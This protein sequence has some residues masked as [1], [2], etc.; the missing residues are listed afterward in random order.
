MKLISLIFKKTALLSAAGFFCLIQWIDVS[1]VLAGPLA[2]E[3][4][5]IAKE[6]VEFDKLMLDYKDLL[7]MGEIKQA[8][9]LNPKLARSAN[10]LT[11]VK[12][13]SS[14]IEKL[15]SGSQGH[16]T[17]LKESKEKAAQA[18]EQ[19]KNLQA[20]LEDLEKRLSDKEAELSKS[21]EE[22][23]NSQSTLRS[24][25]LKNQSAQSNLSS[26]QSKLQSAEAKVDDCKY[27]LTQA[28]SRLETCEAKSSAAG[29][30]SGLTTSSGVSNKTPSSY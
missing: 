25:E 12:D 9:N 14:K 7:D 4:K 10:L 17:E 26:C 30:T 11:R 29:N 20:K 24:Y 5:K 2:D 8:K 3:A 18:E 22:A 16:E 13:L 1:A 28:K 19:L 23:Q 6:A 27:E 21:R 15:E